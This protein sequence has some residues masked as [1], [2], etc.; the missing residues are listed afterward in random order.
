M[1]HACKRLGFHHQNVQSTDGFS[2][3]CSS[4]R[5][6]VQLPELLALRKPLPPL[7][8]APILVKDNFDTIG[9]AATAGAVGLLDNFATE[10]A[11]VVRL[12][13]MHALVCRTL[14]AQLI[15][16]SIAQGSC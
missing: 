9:M 13:S 16:S 4:A 3:E 10:N 7:F 2:S 8:C 6:E 14:N 12:H 1:P 15:L 11:F 5:C